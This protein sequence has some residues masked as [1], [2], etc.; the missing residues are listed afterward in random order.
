MSHSP[1]GPLYSQRNQAPH[2]SSDLTPWKNIFICLQS[3]SILEIFFTVFPHPCPTLNSFLF[4]QRKATAMMQNKTKRNETKKPASKLFFVLMGTSAKYVPS[5]TYKA[6][7]QQ[8][9][10][11]RAPLPAPKRGVKCPTTQPRCP[12]DIWNVELLF[13]PLGLAQAA[14]NSSPSEPGIMRAPAR[15]A[16]LVLAGYQP[17]AGRPRTQ[18]SAFLLHTKPF[19]RGRC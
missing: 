18:V 10:G 13:P 16:W 17:C 7:G 2:G 6:T 4:K 19:H 5:N 12:P 3:K 8:Q 14:L 15:A 1:Q 9:N 11:H